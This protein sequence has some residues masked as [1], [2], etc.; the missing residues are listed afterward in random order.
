MGDPSEFCPQK[1]STWWPAS[2]SAAVEKALA[3]PE[4]MALLAAM[5]SGPAL[6]AIADGAFD[7]KSLMV[8]WLALRMATRSDSCWAADVALSRMALSLQNAVLSPA[9][10]RPTLILTWAVPLLTE[11]T[12]TWT[13]Y[14]VVPPCGVSV[15]SIATPALASSP[16]GQLTFGAGCLIWTHR[17]PS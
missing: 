14:V 11:V 12:V 1:A 7:W 8:L 13:G 4:A 9:P 2:V 3:S 5:A 6:S 17:A 10:A 15:Q 16:P